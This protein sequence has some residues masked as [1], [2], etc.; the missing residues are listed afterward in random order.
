M[1]I[2]II[3]KMAIYTKG[4][5]KGNTGKFS[6]SGN[7]GLRVSKDSLVVEVLG[8]VDEFNSFL[9]IIKTKTTEKSLIRNIKNIQENLLTIGSIT[10]GSGLKFS[11]SETIKLE[12]I[13]D[14]LESSL[15]VLKNFIIPGGDMVAAQLQYARALSRR[16]ERRM[17]AL[18]SEEKVSPFILQYL[19]RL[20]D[21]LFMLARQA[22]F[23]QGQTEEVWKSQK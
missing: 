10:G 7:S 14:S 12:R 3:L 16:V 19:N 23:A 15:P 21:A 18:S 4:G 17:V 13:I 20:S 11:K 9:G 6:S 1:F 8:A 5:D 2:D 22:N